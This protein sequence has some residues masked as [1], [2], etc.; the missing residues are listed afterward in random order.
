MLQTR[1]AKRPAQAAVRFAVDA[2]GEGLLDARARRSRRST[3]RRST[4]CC[5]R[6]STPTPSYE[7]L[8]ARRRRLA[9]RGQ[10][11][12]SCSRADDA[13]AAAGEGRDVDPRAAVHRGR[14]RRRLP[15]RARASSPSEGGKAVARGARR[16]RH[17][18]A[19]R[20][21]RRGAGDRPRRRRGRAS[22]ARSLHEGDLI[23]IDGTTGRDHARRRAA[24]RARRSASTSRRCW[25]GPT[26]CAGSA[27]APTPTRPR[28]RAR[29]REFGAEG[30]GLCR[31]EHMFFGRGAPAAMRAMILAD[32]EPSAPRR[33]RRSCCRSS[34][35][36]FEGLF[37]AM[38]G[39]PVTIRL[40]DPPLHEF[41]PAPAPSSR[42][43]RARADRARRGPAPSSS[44]TLERVQRAQETNPMLGTRGVRLGI[45]YPEIYEMQVGAIFA[46]GG[47][48]DERAGERRSSRSWSRWSTTSASS[49]SCA[50]SIERVGAE[51]R[52]ARPAR[53]PR[54]HDDR[55]AARVLPGRPHRRAAP[56]S[57]RSAPTT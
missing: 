45:L 12:R 55:A 17:G 49:S 25:A 56:T 43:G 28:T 37:E 15:R 41:L 5:T 9:G 54:R 50:S 10:G 44:S 52:P 2:V 27:C 4:R 38:A 39:L 6:R 26:S 3:P 7:V 23:A 20:D 29:A 47:A 21:G 14:R 18:R 46:R 34:R 30:I 40:L 1:N 57:S 31:T 53:L 22:A 11:R 33:A 8:A 36:D 24:R 35:S 13:V 42:R 32:D 19:R 48:V 51:E 16:P